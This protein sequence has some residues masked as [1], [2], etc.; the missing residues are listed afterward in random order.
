MT[1]IAPE[2]DMERQLEEDTRAAWAA[3]NERL[4]GLTGED[5]ELAEHE[6][7]AELQIV[8]R[9]VERRRQLIAR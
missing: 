5:Y 9:R 1:S 8:L 3:Y 6:S 2:T 7:W 4:R